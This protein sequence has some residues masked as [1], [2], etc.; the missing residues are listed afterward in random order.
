MLRKIRLVCACS[1]EKGSRKY[2]GL[3]TIL[4]VMPIAGWGEVRRQH[5]P[6]ATAPTNNTD[7]K[8]KFFLLLLQPGMYNVY[9]H[10][11]NCNENR[12]SFQMAVHSF[13]RRSVPRKSKLFSFSSHNRFVVA[14]SPVSCKENSR[15]KKNPYLLTAQLEPR[16]E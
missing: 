5:K 16:I 2:G 6:V 4:M 7:R 11:I 3:A 1:K 13:S 14:Q 8:M 10:R 12:E 9:H 15:R